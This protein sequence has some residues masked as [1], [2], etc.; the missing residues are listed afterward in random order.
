[1]GKI[2][3][4]IKQLCQCGVKRAKLVDYAKVQ[5]GFAFNSKLF[6]EDSANIPLIRIRDVIP[7]KPSTYYLGEYSDEYI[8]K[9][10]DILVGMDGNFNLEKWN[11]RNGLLNQRVC[12]IF[13]KNAG[14]LLDGF[15]YHYL[16][17]VFKKIENSI[18]GS[19]VKHL[20]AKVI[21]GI[22]IPLPP[23]A[24]QKKI[25]EILDTFTGMIGNLQKELEQ[26]QKQFEYYRE[27]LFAKRHNELE[28]EYVKNIALNC[29]A[30]ATPSTK[31]K[32]YWEGGNIP[33]MSS[34]EVHQ[35]Q[36]LRVEGR[37]TQKGYDHCSTKMVPRDS[38]VIALA[39]QGKTRGTVAITRIELCT[40]Q[41][42]CAIV[43]DKTKVLPDYL[44]YYLK[45]QYFDLRR[46][47]SGDGTRGGLNL[48]MINNYGIPIVSLEHQREIVEILDTFEALISNIKQE[49]EMRQ[50]QYEFYREK[51]L[52]FE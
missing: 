42:I 30:G 33:W 44:Y 18:Q 22:E 3:E 8:V 47:S 6:T 28:W 5:Y 51:L 50:K 52:T 43:P 25:V 23:L 41:S 15:L 49:I 31:N 14:M 4:L 11:D 13:T 21:N 45:G 17:P 2:D 24:V 19:T 40:N 34:G 36:V 32:E 48:K 1:M 26:R 9:K 29:Y 39:G 38:V 16:K 37:I 20:S 27:I 10:G 12:K 46:L 35:G 7:G